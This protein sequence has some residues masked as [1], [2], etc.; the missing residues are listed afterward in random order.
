MR[1][2]LVC[3]MFIFIVNITDA[4]MFIRTSDLFPA[5]ISTPGSGELNII[6][7]QQVDTLMSRYILGNKLLNNGMEG[8]RIQIYRSSIRNASEESN[9][10]R[11]DFM[12]EFPGITSYAE[13][14]KP[15]YFLVRA[16]DFRTKLDGAKTLAEVKRKFPNAYMVPCIIS[17]PDLN[18]K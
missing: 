2:L 11:A 9:K 13:F 10:V 4:Q 15:N 5:K 12:V 18:K 3:L 8:F 14:E 6:Q 7:P 16:G 17:F 1:A